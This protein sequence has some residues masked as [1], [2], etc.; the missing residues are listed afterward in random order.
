MAIIYMISSFFRRGSTPTNPA[1]TEGGKSAEGYAY[2]T[3]QFDKGT[4]MVFSFFF[5]ALIN[6]RKAIVI[7][8]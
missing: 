7:S 8:L 2:T 6:S 3:N 4:F 1:T 5:I